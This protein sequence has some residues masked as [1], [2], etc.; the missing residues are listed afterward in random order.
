M[1]LLSPKTKKP[2]RLLPSGFLFACLEGFFLPARLNF[3]L[4]YQVNLRNVTIMVLYTG[5]HTMTTPKDAHT[6]AAAV[7]C[8]LPMVLLCVFSV[9]IVISLPNLIP[10]SGI[11]T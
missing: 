6:K 11:L 10:M 2:G 8:T 5:R 1:Q 4:I 9:N 7:P 3:F